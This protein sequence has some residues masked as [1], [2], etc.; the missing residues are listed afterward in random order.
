M[1]TI[2]KQAYWNELCIKLKKKFPQ[3]TDKDLK[4]REG[5]EESMMRMIEYKLQKTKEEMQEIVD[6]MKFFIY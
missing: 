4:Y 1:Q 3:L 6:K 2:T 5:K